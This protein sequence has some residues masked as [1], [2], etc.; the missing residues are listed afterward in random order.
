M[1]KVVDTPAGDLDTDGVGLRLMVGVMLGD[2]ETDGDPLGV[3]VMD[4]VRDKVA[5]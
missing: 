2:T 3:T 1:A 4:G 5:V